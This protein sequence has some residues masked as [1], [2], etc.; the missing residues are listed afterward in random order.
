MA[1]DDF[2]IIN[3]IIDYELPQTLPST[4]PTLALLSVS[5]WLLVIKLLSPW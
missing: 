1:H 5:G 2:T 4:Q 3:I